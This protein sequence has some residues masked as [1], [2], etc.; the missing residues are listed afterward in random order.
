MKDAIAREDWEE[1]KRILQ[2]HLRSSATESPKVT[3]DLADIGHRITQYS[4]DLD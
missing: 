4:E 1:V 2:Q 3:R